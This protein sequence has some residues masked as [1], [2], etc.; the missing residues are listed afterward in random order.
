[1]L[2]GSASTDRNATHSSLTYAWDLS[3]NGIFD[4]ADV[5]GPTPSFSAVGLSP[6]SYTVGSA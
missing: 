6:G 3:D 2:N 1:M 4:V 5:T